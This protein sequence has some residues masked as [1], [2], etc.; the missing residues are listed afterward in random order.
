MD[1]LKTSVLATQF[2]IFILN[3][4]KFSVITSF[5]L[6]KCFGDRKDILAYSKNFSSKRALFFVLAKKEKKNHKEGILRDLILY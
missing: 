6:D 5:L 2:V 4:Q 1:H 3:R